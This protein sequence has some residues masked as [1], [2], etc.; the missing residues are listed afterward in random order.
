MTEL[1]EYVNKTIEIKQI[2]DTFSQD[3]N[4]KKF[5]QLTTNKKFTEF[6]WNKLRS[7][8]NT[9]DLGLDANFWNEPVPDEIM[10]ILRNGL[11]MF[12][13]L[14][15]E[16]ICTKKK[17]S[18]FVFDSLMR[19]FGFIGTVMS[20]NTK[21]NINTHLAF[22]LTFFR[23]E[24]D[25]FNALLTFVLETVKQIVDEFEQ[26]PPDSDES[27]KRKRHE[28]KK[29]NRSVRNKKDSKKK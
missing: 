16:N 10:Q 14:E 21:T 17:L 2:L 5:L 11:P 23:F 22:V 24:N 7:G 3:E 20:L 18:V 27:N 15:S 8:Y 6:T 28:S 1:V 9:Q 13:N 26:L 19:D 25:A 12:D 4:M 29:T